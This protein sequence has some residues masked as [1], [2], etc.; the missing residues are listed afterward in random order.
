MTNL[1][2]SLRRTLIAA[3]AL[4]ALAAAPASANI[5]VTQVSTDPFTNSSSQH[6]TELEPD[7]FSSGGT[8]V[9][10]F[11]VGRCFDGGGSDIG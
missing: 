1:T 9:S 4:G 11:Q 8:L 2:R 10:A 7:T 6:A 3:A 5:S